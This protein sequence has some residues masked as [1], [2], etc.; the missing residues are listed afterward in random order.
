MMQESLLTCTVVNQINKNF[1]AAQN[2]GK[3]QESREV[4]AKRRNL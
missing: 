2:G 4:T 1:W 3:G